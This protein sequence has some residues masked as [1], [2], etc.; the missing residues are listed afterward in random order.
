MSKVNWWNESRC[1]AGHVSFLFFFFRTR[2]QDQNKNTKNT[3]FS[4]PYLIFF[5]FFCVRTRKMISTTFV[6]KPTKK[7]SPPLHVCK[8]YEEDVHF[9]L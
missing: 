1:V 8:S 4:S 2:A 7:E 3:L 6:V 5:F 9:S